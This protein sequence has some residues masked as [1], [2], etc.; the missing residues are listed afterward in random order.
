MGDL[1][2]FPSQQAQGLAF[3]DREL[4]QLLSAKG[5]DESLI[6]FAA[7]ELTGIYADLSAAEQ[8][9]FSLR[10]PPGL[11]ASERESLEG[12]INEGLADIR[13]DNHAL[14]VNLIAQL[15]LAKIRIYE[16]ERGAAKP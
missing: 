13:R 1:L 16:L 6:E 10:V 11:S 8:Y 3:L 4:R 5:A 15:V 12:Q 14:T 9:G 7:K 2:K